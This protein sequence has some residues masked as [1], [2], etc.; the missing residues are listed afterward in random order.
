[1]PRLRPS[2]ML[3]TEDSDEDDLQREYAPLGMLTIAIG[4]PHGRD[5]RFASEQ[6]DDGDDGS[7]SD[8]DIPKLSAAELDAR[9]KSCRCE[10]DCLLALRRGDQDAARRHNQE[11]QQADKQMAKLTGNKGDD[12]GE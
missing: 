11:L 6:Q 4:L 3:A 12:D 2:P 9:I 10:L 8:G 7:N 1:M 5:V